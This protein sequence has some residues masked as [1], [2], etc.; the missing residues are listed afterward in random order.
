[1]REIRL[2]LVEDDPESWSAASKCIEE[3]TEKPKLNVNG[4]A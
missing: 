3:F 4:T 2:L 1:M